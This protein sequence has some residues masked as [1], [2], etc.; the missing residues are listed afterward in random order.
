MSHVGQ[1]LVSLDNKYIQQAVT[2]TRETI[3]IDENN[4]K[5]LNI[6]VSDFHTLRILRNCINHAG[7][8]EAGA[9]EIV[10]EYL[11]DTELIFGF[12]NKLLAKVRRKYEKESKSK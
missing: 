1:F 11:R 2:F 4:A 5:K 9:H 7:D 6:S 12:V 8:D 3:L 10:D